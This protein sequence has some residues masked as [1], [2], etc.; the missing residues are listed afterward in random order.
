MHVHW[1]IRWHMM[2]QVLSSGLDQLP[3]NQRILDAFF[4][5]S[6]MRHFSQ[7]SGGLVTLSILWKHYRLVSPSDL[8]FCSVSCQHGVS[9]LSVSC[10]RRASAAVHL[11]SPHNPTSC[12][13][14]APT[15]PLTQNFQ[16][17]PAAVLQWSFCAFVAFGWIFLKSLLWSPQSLLNLLPAKKRSVFNKTG[18]AVRPPPHLWCGLLGKMCCSFWS[19]E[20]KVLDVNRLLEACWYNKEKMK[21]W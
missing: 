6:G 7:N 15:P 12:W 19:E 18:S 14:S 2:S 16:L 10:H 1:L 20:F 13:T 11:A 21:K 17:P 5:I 3:S 8:L 9:G 4:W